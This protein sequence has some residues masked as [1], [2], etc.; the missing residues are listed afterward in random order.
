[1][2]VAALIT[3]IITAGGGFVLLATWVSHGGHKNPPSSS[4]FPPALI[5]GH[6]ALAAIGLVVWIVFVANGSQGVGWVAVV[7]LAIVAVMGFTMLA[8]WLPERR[9]TG[10]AATATRVHDAVTDPAERHFPVAVVG[11]HG[12][13]A[14]TTLVLALVATL[15]A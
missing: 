5:F 6:F 12:L 4:R 13:L 9:K 8:R 15:Q 3:W 11:L 7:L 1:M 2:D 14:A 10:V